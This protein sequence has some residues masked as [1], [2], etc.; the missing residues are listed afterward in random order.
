MALISA[1]GVGEITPNVDVDD[2]QLQKLFAACAACRLPVIVHLVH[3]R[4]K[5]YG[6]YDD[7]G[8]PRIE[9]LLADLPD[10]TLI[11]HSTVFWSEISGDVTEASR[12]QY[13]TGPVTEGGRV[14]ELMRRYPNL[15]CDVSAGSGH[16]A[17]MRDPDFTARFIEEFS[18]RILYGCDITA[19]TVPHPLPFVE[20]LEQMVADGKLS[21][22]NYCKL[23]RDNAIR[24]L[25]L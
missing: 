4:G 2:P 5:G 23:V 21:E 12:C 24:I 11:G 14:V 9:K 3:V 17:L 25:N 18:D 15:C 10:L 6:M 8:L 1:K 16:N 7:L 22:E 13:P 20:F 19:T